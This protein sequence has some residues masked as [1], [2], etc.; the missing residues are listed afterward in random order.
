MMFGEG[1]RL[2]DLNGRAQRGGGIPVGGTAAEAASTVTGEG[3]DGTG[4]LAGLEGAAAAL[5]GSVGGAR[6][7]DE[8][9]GSTSGRGGGS[10]CS[11]CGRGLKEQSERGSGT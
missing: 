5:A 9:L 7:G 1:V 2:D 10:R 4:T 11:G 8:G 3:N 6:R